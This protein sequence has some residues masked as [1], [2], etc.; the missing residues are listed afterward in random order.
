MST[1]FDPETLL[2]EARRRT[3][4]VDFGDVEFREPLAIICR[5]LA[6]E[7]PLTNA[8]RAAQR[9][10]LIG[11][12]ADRLTLL[13]WTR[14]HPDIR[15]EVLDPPVVIAGLPRTGT[16]ML[17]RML[18]AA[19]GIAV[20]LFYEAV[21]ISPPLDW[22]FDGEDPRLPAARTMVAAMNDAMPELASIYPFDAEAPE[23]SLFLYQPSLISTAE[24][25]TALVP[26]YDAWFAGADKRSAY[27]YLKLTVQ[28]L[29]WQRKRQGRYAGER[30]LLKTPDHLHGLSELLDV[31]PAAHLIQTHRDPIETIPS[32]CSFIR[33]LHSTSTARD[34]SRDIG[35]AWSSMFARA[36]ERADAVRATNSDRFID[37]WYKDTVAEPRQVA[38]TVFGF[39]GQELTGAGWAEMER[40][41]EANKREARPTHRYTLEEFGL[42][43]DGIKRDFKAYRAR[44]IEPARAQEVV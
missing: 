34:D 33:V 43:E 12:L 36:L 20:P 26:A 32:I 6:G 23:E 39:I 1:E 27:R 18:S 5:S 44:Y 3:G 2:D 37:V 11:L 10:R 24:Q 21:T 14:R 8:G 4:L 41:R 9:E 35:A 42:S 15:D 28:F 38:E 25:S 29:Q 19:P 13:E 17:Y 30:W 40:W 16:T 31:F 22:G 7:A